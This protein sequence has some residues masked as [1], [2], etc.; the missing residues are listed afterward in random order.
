LKIDR[1][2]VNDLDKRSDNAAI[3][4][5]IIG[6]GESLGLSIIAEGV[7]RQAQAERLKVLG[8]TLAQGYLYSRPLPARLLE[9]YPTDDLSS[10]SRRK[11][12]AAS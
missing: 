6:L 10:W 11:A 4:R 5:A 3:V 7:E 8:C 1:S 12:V 2:F 9:P